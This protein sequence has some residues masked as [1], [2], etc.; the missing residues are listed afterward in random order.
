MTHFLTSASAALVM[1]VVVTRGSLAVA[2][3]LEFITRKPR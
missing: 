2:R 1:Y 3:S